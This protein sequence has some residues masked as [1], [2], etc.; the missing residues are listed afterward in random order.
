MEICGKNKL[1]P[2]ESMNGLGRVMLIHEEML[3]TPTCMSGGCMVRIEE[4]NG[5]R[6]YDYRRPEPERFLTLNMIMSFEPKAGVIKFAREPNIEQAVGPGGESLAKA[7]AREPRFM[8]VTNA[9]FCRLV[10][11][12]NY[13]Q[14]VKSLKTYSGKIWVIQEVKSEDWVVETDKAVGATR[15]VCDLDTLKILGLKLQNNMIILD[16]EIAAGGNENLVSW[17]RIVEGMRY[18]SPAGQPAL[19]HGNCNQTIRTNGG[20]QILTGSIQSLPT[21]EGEVVMPSKLVIR[22]PS[23]VKAAAV[24]FEF[25]D[26]ELP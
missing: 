7:N 15:T 14:G 19:R 18:E 4:S 6:Y 23:E 3:K 13:R 21:E 12:L 5:R 16:M 1:K 10:A 17:N 20:K 11:N 9:G 25:K 8:D 2:E 26:V 24:P 22:L